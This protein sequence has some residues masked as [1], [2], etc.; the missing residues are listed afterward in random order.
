MDNILD[1]L[2]DLTRPD[3]RPPEYFALLEKSEPYIK[4][5]KEHFSLPFVDGLTEAQCEA[6]DWL[7]K[8]CFS[9]GF[10]LGVHLTL[11]GLS[12]HT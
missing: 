9:R 2:E 1:L 8:E 6:S 4:A 3:Y 10:R 12:Y 5:A 11:E 7:Q